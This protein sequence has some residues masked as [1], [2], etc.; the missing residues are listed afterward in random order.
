MRTRIC[1]ISSVHVSS[2]TRILHRECAS[3]AEAGFDVF[4]LVVNQEDREEKGVRV[5][6]VS[7]PVRNRLDRMRKAPAALFEEVL[8]LK[9]AICHFHDPELLPLGRRLQKAGFSVIYDVHEHVPNQIRTKKYL[10]RLLRIPIALLVG[11]YE[12][13]MAA[14]MDAVITAT[15]LVRDRFLKRNRRSVMI[16]NYPRLDT[17]IAAAAGKKHDLTYVGLINEIRGIRQLLDAMVLLP[18]HRLCLV[19]RFETDALQKEMEDHPAWSQVDYVGLKSRQEVASILAESKIGIVTFLPAPNHNKNQPNK[20]FEYMAASLPVVC[21]HF[22]RW[23]RIV[24]EANCG[25]CVDPV[26]PQA[27]AASCSQLLNDPEARSTMGSNGRKAMEDQYNWASEEQ[28]L[29]NLYAELL[30]K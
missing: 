11:W 5:R 3:L 12:D 20:L 28:A 2:D 29:L 26:D 7:V 9:P 6:S 19:G 30:N 16:N 10:P 18:D 21:S 23:R 27:I 17:F 22:E 1:H 14:R 15:D 24:E 4:L 25:I 13:R 8:R